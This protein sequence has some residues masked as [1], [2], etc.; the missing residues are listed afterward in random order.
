MRRSIEPVIIRLS[1]I[2]CKSKLLKYFSNNKP[3]IATGIEA[4]I[5]IKDILKPSLFL[6]AYLTSLSPEKNPTM[7]FI[8]SL[9]NIKHV[10]KNVP[11]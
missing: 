2:L 1:P 4:I 6:L 5:T 8:I 9:R 11:K 7:A 10:A 3:T